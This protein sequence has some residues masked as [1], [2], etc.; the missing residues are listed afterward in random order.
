MS[1]IKLPDGNLIDTVIAHI[2]ATI[3]ASS[4]ANL[5]GFEMDAFLYFSGQELW[6][7]DVH[8]S[9]E[10]SCL[11]RANLLLTE[12]VATVQDIA[13]ALRDVWQSIMYAD[14]GACSINWYREATCLRFV[15]AIADKFYVTGTALAHG[16]NYPDL[17]A[18]FDRDFSRL[19]APLRSLPGGVPSWAAA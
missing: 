1:Q 9:D 11:I 13:T 4:G 2:T 16:P 5:L 15:T 6:H 19:R 3:P 18:A 8:R 14:F 12:K 17:V 10:P 7:A